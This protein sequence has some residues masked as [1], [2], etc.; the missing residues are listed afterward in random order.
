M[1]KVF[2]VL[3]FLIVNVQVNLA[4]TNFLN[5]TL[6]SNGQMQAGLLTCAGATGTGLPVNFVYK[7]YRGGFLEP[8]YLNS[9]ESKLR[10]Y[11]SIGGSGRN[12]INVAFDKDS[13]LI[14]KT[15]LVLGLAFEEHWNASANFSKDIFHLTFFGNDGFDNQISKLDPAWFRVFN[16][17]QYSLELAYNKQVKARRHGL[18]IQLNYLEGKQFSEIEIIRGSFYT[19]TYGT[20]VDADLKGNYFQSDTARNGVGRFDKGNG[21]GVGFSFVYSM[22]GPKT[23]IF[24]GIK[25]AGYIQWNANSLLLSADTTVHLKGYQIYSLKDVSDS[26]FTLSV[27]SLRNIAPQSRYKKYKMYLP[28]K[29]FFESQHLMSNSAF[30]ILAGFRY[31][32]D[33]VYLPLFYTGFVYSKCWGGVLRSTIGY[34]GYTKVNLGIEYSRVFMRHFSFG[35]G[36]NQAEGIFSPLNPKGFSGFVGLRY[37]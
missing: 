28:A 33:P 20:R 24:L 23:K 16:Y 2:F 29:I 5:D 4:Q 1:R 9:M 14:K 31:I 6:S 7:F 30:S 10:D 18:Q 13:F 25:D 37:N 3:F 26:L 36:I 12:R 34:G 17:R 21:T 22:Q 35:I 11:N 8:S 32:A 27:D 19:S 15:G